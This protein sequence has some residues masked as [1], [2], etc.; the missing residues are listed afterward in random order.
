M[1]NVDVLEIARERHGHDDRRVLGHAKDEW[2]AGRGIK[3]DNA[4][5]QTK[6][7]S[8]VGRMGSPMTRLGQDIGEEIDHGGVGARVRSSR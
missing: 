6:H 4:P 1:G 8:L 7:G 5:Y 3:R 2:L